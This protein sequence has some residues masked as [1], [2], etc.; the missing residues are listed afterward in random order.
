MKI[1]RIPSYKEEQ[2]SKLAV[3]DMFEYLDALYIKVDDFNKLGII[4]PPLTLGGG[5][6]DASD[7]IYNAVNLHDGR[8]EYVYPTNKVFVVSGEVTYTK[9]ESE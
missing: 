3:G 1:K 7:F 6:R 2:Y 4:T 9:V 5:G 8:F